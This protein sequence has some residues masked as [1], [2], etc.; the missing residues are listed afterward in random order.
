MLFAKSNATSLTDTVLV[1]SSAFLHKGAGAKNVNGVRRHNDPQANGVKNLTIKNN[2]FVDWSNG[3]PVIIEG[4]QDWANYLSQSNF[5]NLAI[6]GNDFI[7]TGVRSDS[8][9]VILRDLRATATDVKRI[10]DNDFIWQNASTEAWSGYDSPWVLADDVAGMSI[11]NNRFSGG[12]D[13]PQILVWDST[14]VTPVYANTMAGVG[15]DP[16]AKEN[17]RPYWL[18][19]GMSNVANAN[20]NSDLATMWPS[21]ARLRSSCTSSPSNRLEIDLEPPIKDFAYNTLPSSTVDVDVYV[22]PASDA[23]LTRRVNA[24]GTT[25]T[26]AAVPTFANIT[27]TT[28]QTLTISSA[29][30]TPGDLVRVQIQESGANR[31]GRTSQLSR[32]ATITTFA[33]CGPTLTI[34]RAAANPAQGANTNS[35]TLYWDIASDESLAAS[36]SGALE[37]SDFTFTASP[38]VV[39]ASA[40]TVLATSLTQTT[41]TDANQNPTMRRKWRM[42]A[43]IT[44][45][46]LVR[47]QLLAGTVANRLG[48]LN[49]DAVS[50][51]GDAQV[52]Y[53]QSLSITKIGSATVTPGPALAVTLKEGETKIFTIHGGRSLNPST[54]VV[55]LTPTASVVSP[56]GHTAPVVEY[57]KSDGTYADTGVSYEMRTWG[58]APA[59]VEVTIR[60]INNAVVDGARTVDVT[61][62]SSSDPAAGGDS[63]FHGLSVGPVTVTVLDDDA[64]AVLEQSSLA[65]V[66][67]TALATGVET[68]EVTATIKNVGGLVVPNAPVI[69]VLPA[70]VA[71]AGPSGTVTPEWF[72]ESSVRTLTDVNGVATVRVTSTVVGSSY[73]VKAKLAEGRMTVGGNV[74]ELTSPQWIKAGNVEAVAT[75]GF[76]GVTAP[77]NLA[78]GAGLTI[79]GNSTSDEAIVARVNGSIVASANAV[80][81]A[82]TLAIPA[83]VADGA[84]V[85]VTAAKGGLVSPAATIDWRSAPAAPTVDPTGGTEF[86]GTGTPGMKIEVWSYD[87]IALQSTAKVCPTSGTVLVGVN[88]KWSCTITGTPLAPSASFIVKSI[89]P[90]ASGRSA[91]SGVQTVKAAATVSGLQEYPGRIDTLYRIPEDG[92]YVIGTTP[93]TD[94]DAGDVVPG[95]EVVVTSVAGDVLCTVLGSE[96]TLTG[97]D[98]GKFS[99]T[100]NPAPADGASVKVVVKVPAFTRVQPVADVIDS[101]A[102]QPTTIS[103]NDAAPNSAVT[104]TVPASGGGTTTLCT[105]RSNGSGVWS[106]PVDAADLPPAGTDLTVAVSESMTT[107][108]GTVTDS[109]TAVAN[110]S[111]TLTSG[112]DEVCT[113]T[114]NG[115]GEFTCTIPTSE[116]P[117]NNAVLNATSGGNPV[118]AVTVSA[119]DATPVVTTSTGDIDDLTTIPGR[120]TLAGTTT[121]NTPVTVTAPA[122]GGGTTTLCLEPVTSDP[123]GAWH[124]QASAA[125]A[126]AVIQDGGNLTVAA[127]PPPELATQAV[128]DTVFG[129]EVVG[130]TVTVTVPDGATAS[131]V[132][133]G[134]TIPLVAGSGGNATLTQDAN[135]NDVWTYTSPTPIPNGATVGVTATLPDGQS[136]SLTTPVEA[137]FAGGSDGNTVS[138]IAEAGAYISVTVDV[139]T[140]SG[141]AP[142]N[143]TV[144]V[145][146]GS[147]TLGTTTANGSGVW[148]LDVPDSA[149]PSTSTT[150]TVSA[151]V[152]TTIDGVVAGAPNGTSVTLA[153]GSHLVTETVGAGGAFEVTVPSDWVPAGATSLTAT[154]TDSNSVQQSSTTPVTVTVLPEVA[155]GT[156]TAGGGTDPVAA[157]APG[158]AYALDADNDEVE[159]CHAIAG[160]NGVW[161]CEKD[162]SLDVALLADGAVL[163]VTAEIGGEL[164]TDG[165]YI[166]GSGTVYSTESMAVTGALH[167][168]NVASDGVTVTGIAPA[169]STVQAMGPDPSNPGASVPISTAALA[170]ATT[171]AFTVTLYEPAA[172]GTS[173]AIQATQTVD[174]QVITYAAKKT[175]PTVTLAATLASN[176]GTVSGLAAPGA[177]VV[178]KNAAG[179]T[180]CTATAS[181]TGIW[182][183]RPDSTVMLVSGDR[184]TATFTA[185]GGAG[186][187]QTLTATVAS[188]LQ[189]AANQ[190]GTEI[191]GTAPAE[192]LVTVSE[193]GVEP[194]VLPQPAELSG[195]FTVLLPKPYAAGSVFVVEAVATDGTTY[196]ARVVVPRMAV[197]S[198]GALAQGAPSLTVQAVRRPVTG[199][200]TA[201]LDGN[202]IEAV[203]AA[204]E[205]GASIVIT[206]TGY[207]TTLG[208]LRPDGNQVALRKNTLELVP[209]NQVSLTGIGVQP[210]GPVRVYLMSEPRLLSQFAAAD[211]G[212]Y[213]AVVQIPRDIERG[214]HT[215]Q[216]NAFT[217][218]GHVRSI[219]LGVSVLEPGAYDTRTLAG[220]KKGSA[221]LTAPMKTTLHEIATSAPAGLRIDVAGIVARKAG[222]TDVRLATQRASNVASFL[223]A[224][225]WPG[226]TTI[227]AAVRT[228]AG[229]TPQAVQLGLWLP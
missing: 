34:T 162:P 48:V 152:G 84:K 205:D 93:P 85:S 157:A 228:S 7:Q 203:V 55:T 24:D 204:G 20:A 166:P 155:L 134:V 91:E 219:S 44:G 140:I 21:A 191:V 186:L 222:T 202:P 64:V 60:A 8:R 124:C 27:S 169:G 227:G 112:G 207:R 136:A 29:S 19:R 126:A 59:D 161:S 213:V 218:D 188:A 163:G 72:G 192:A 221:K 135:G 41:L 164:D 212:S 40:P 3:R 52:T 195:A 125:V 67:G 103:G 104:V 184:V 182:T 32:T 211:D 61:V 46:G 143:S 215:L 168:V 139:T 133:N 193:N 14:S 138:G 109:G 114:T 96:I 118:D 217:A 68:R 13:N 66:P 62:A 17:E 121:P 101:S 80:V 201:S 137:S 224:A 187:Y 141:T 25:A 146:S 53:S 69:F 178:V 149:L 154:W 73:N 56:S 174:G 100:L 82:F 153:V 176:G 206:G 165:N 43:T 97:N 115:S 107:V 9:A 2:T 79:T 90:N 177:T 49:A 148:Q 127:T 22:G 87:A 39:G 54:A 11:Y 130:S 194:I 144:T 158:S 216:L 30:F 189:A 171:G 116:A 23:G 45:E 210:N 38:A 181:T 110:Q 150:F 147:T 51:I 92:S 98:A 63:A 179:T 6:T 42:V 15:F 76:V 74:V 18:A 108:T 220:F 122:S 160:A 172:T 26:D 209:G 47:P 102:E 71:F 83:T 37:L 183:C 36:G 129:A 190:G 223:K 175:A 4:I 185:I 58:S 99:C 77:T 35:R 12:K 120:V 88:G 128:V 106:C 16:T 229:K 198:P 159:V 132:I 57:R 117:V 94:L 5:D 31:S 142:A 78:L 145:E 151:D 226:E 208:Q 167:D 65:A 214:N 10:D 113:T 180:L 225:S 1:E 200:G 28:A 33:D 197:I 105:A 123:D 70:G 173:I 75:V 95:T 170:D 50:L 86:T 156:V 89:N 119:A 131:V 199:M 81:G 111:V 196:R